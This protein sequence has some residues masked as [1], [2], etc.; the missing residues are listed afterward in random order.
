MKT[1]VAPF[2]VALAILGIS[3]VI[4]TAPTGTD[5]RPE[6]QRVFPQ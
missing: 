1:A 5:T 2:I 3:V 4:Y 6:Y